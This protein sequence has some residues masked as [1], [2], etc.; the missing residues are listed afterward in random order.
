MYTIYHDQGWIEV[1]CGSMFCGKTEELLRRIRRVKIAGKKFQVFKP[2]IDNRYDK[3]CVVSHNNG[4]IQATLVSIADDILEKLE[5]DT[6]V[7][8]IDEA[9]FF[10]KKIVAVCEKMASDGIRVIVAGLD[11][12][13]LGRAFEPMPKLM[14]VAECVL[15][16]HAICKKCGNMASK[17][18]RLKGS[19]QQ[20]EVGHSDSYE[21]RCRHCFELD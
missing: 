15:K 4:K 13:Y 3:D 18:K 19:D 1:I 5:E 8:A 21:A 12:D 20:I 16:L 9:Q 14:A 6:K 10:D 17:S 2:E 11:Q 7:V